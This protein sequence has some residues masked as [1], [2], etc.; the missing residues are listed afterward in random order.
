MVGDSDEGLITARRNRVPAVLVER[1]ERKHSIS[2]D[3]VIH[4]LE[5]L[6]V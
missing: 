2:P 1:E 6:D 4:G 3:Y 5:E